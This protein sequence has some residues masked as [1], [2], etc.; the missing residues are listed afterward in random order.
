MYATSRFF[1]AMSLAIPSG[2]FAQTCDAALLPNAGVE[3]G[4]LVL[5]DSVTLTT[6]AWCGGVSDFTPEAW[7]E[8]SGDLIGRAG[9]TADG[10]V[11]ELGVLREG[12]VL[13]IYIFLPETGET[14]YTGA[15]DN[16]ADGL[17]HAAI[18]D[19]GNGTFRVGF[20]DTAGGGDFDYDDVNLVISA[21]ATVE[22]DTDADGLWDSGDLCPLDDRNDNDGDGL[23]ESSDNCNAYPNADQTDADADGIG[24]P[25]DPAMFISEAI[26]G[27]AGQMNVWSISGASP[28]APLE[29]YRGKAKGVLPVTSC[30]GLYLGLSRPQL[31]A[32]PTA[33]MAGNA[34]LSKW[35]GGTASGTKET[36]QVLDR[37]NCTVSQV[38]ITVIQ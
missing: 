11:V 10:E 13:S 6:A 7:L 14:F 2:A 26:P 21:N 19:L 3:G 1:F 22:I 24:D 15:G 17:V 23:C 5:A 12:S 8:S 16:N 9:E 34:I 27:I 29:I 30:P 33:D 25:C 32:T 37:V 4:T 20:E 35:L 36:V 28:L 31:L 18:E 38:Q